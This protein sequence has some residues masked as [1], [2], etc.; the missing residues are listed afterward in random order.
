MSHNTQTPFL[1]ICF[2]YFANDLIKDTR[3]AEEEDP[4]YA[5]AESTIIRE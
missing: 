2:A 5:L 3:S 4:K 1:P